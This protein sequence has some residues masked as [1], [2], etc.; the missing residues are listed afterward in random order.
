M[1]VGIYTCIKIEL[2]FQ[3]FLLATSSTYS[4]RSTTTLLRLLTA[5]ITISSDGPTSFASYSQ[6]VRLCFFSEEQK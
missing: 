2:P 1:T 6:Y 4:L 5:V 3:C